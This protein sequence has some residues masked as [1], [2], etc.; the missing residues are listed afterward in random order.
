MSVTLLKRIFLL[1]A[2]TAL[3]VVLAGLFDS[4][5]LSAMT[6]VSE[7]IIQIGGW[8]CLAAGALMVF[9]GTRARPPIALC[10]TIIIGNLG[11]VAAS[12]ATIIAHQ[13]SI[14]PLGTMLV[15]AQAAGVLVLS[16]LEAAGT[17]SLS[18]A[19]A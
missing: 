13:G 7:G 1:D 2:A 9:V 18:A 8:I 10:W 3:I 4:A 16:L 19:A 17:R 15:A 6:G 12:I 14:T 5:P 11:W